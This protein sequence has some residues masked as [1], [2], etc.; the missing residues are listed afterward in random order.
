[1]KQQLLSAFRQLSLGI[2]IK[3]PWKGRHW[4]NH[5]VETNYA[6]VEAC[7]IGCVSAIAALILK[8]G[9]GLL[10]Q[11]RLQ[12]VDQTGVYILPIVGLVL[13]GLAGLLLETC[14]PSAKGGGIPQVKAAL[15]K[16][17]VPLSL[18]VAVVKMLGTML[19]LGAGMTLGRR[20]PTVH[21]GA[22]LAAQLSNWVPTSP[23]HRRQMI[24]AGAAAGLAAGFNTPIAGVLFVVEELSRDMSGLTLETAILASFTGSIVSRLLGST[25][26]KLV[27]SILPLS[28]THFTS[29]E[30][31]FYL[32]LGAL[33]GVLGASFNRGVLLCLRFYRW[34]NI[35]LIWQIA[36]AGLISGAI[37]ALSP[38]I[39]RDNAGLRDFLITGYAT[40]QKSTFVF[41]AHFCLT[42]LAYGSGAPGG[43]FAPALVLGSA[44]GYLVGMAEVATLGIGYA[45]TY[46]L[47]GMSAFFTAVARVP[48]TAIVIV[49]EMT[50]DFTLVLPL[51]ISSVV[52]YGVA[53]TIKKGSLY[54]HLLQ[55]SGIELSDEGAQNE[56]LSGLKA[57]DVMK[58][59]VESFRPDMTLE[60]VLAAFARSAHHGFPVLDEE[61]LVGMVT[62]ANLENLVSQESTTRLRD[63]MTPRP[64]TVQPDGSL[65][66]VVYLMDRYQLSHLPVTEGRRLLGII[67]RSDL[68]HA[69][70]DQLKMTPKI[71]GAKVEPSYLVYQT[72]SP[73]VGKGRLLLPLANPQTAQALVKI[74]G[75]IAQQQGYELECLHIVTVPRHIAPSQASVSLKKSHQLLKEAK[76]EAAAWDIPLHVQIRLAHNLAQAILEVIN[77][78][79]IDL[80]IMGWKGNTS[81]P[82]RIFG[83]AVDT[84]IR[85]APCDVAMIKLGDGKQSFPYRDYLATNWLI[86]I[87]GGPNVQRAVQLLPG[88]QLLARSR[89][90]FLCQVHPP[91][92]N[93]PDTRILQEMAAQVKLQLNASVFPIPIRSASVSDAIIRL[94][95]S[96]DCQVIIVGASREGLLQQAIHG[97]IPEAI[98]SGV[99]STV[100]LVRSAV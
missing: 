77:E 82:G 56:V 24:A 39:L 88:L 76:R 47:V 9:I 49:F 71:K 15:A 74:A 5:A 86:P 13:G 52:A 72:R 55:A 16:F 85:E 87:A 31:P 66:D 81:S 79:H 40:W 94:A 26:L 50:A 17:P 90:V 12:L 14:S 100:I 92:T 41:I 30:I 91:D 19:I 18:R 48:I 89:H 46:A 99:K 6:L 60:E 23:Q 75:A 51:M 65:S 42:I 32:L 1:M 22:A 11:F 45:S 38:P 28:E 69:T 78:R 54:Q 95:E 93:I 35:S 8:E 84:L 68:I 29:P 44:L 3:R 62:E 27:A 59:R 20:G 21:I 96:E 58:R 64:V 80:L 25:D 34:L 67:T 98:T 4:G 37:I 53:E 33:A 73:A 10:G 7:L 36:L 70:A 43:L 83:D 2:T 61:K 57:V 97:N 63:I